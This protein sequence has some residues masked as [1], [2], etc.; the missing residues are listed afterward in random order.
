MLCGCSTTDSVN[1][2]GGVEQQQ[3]V[4]LEKAESQDKVIPLTVTDAG[5]ERV[6]VG[7][8]TDTPDELQP[9]QADEFFPGTGVFL[10]QP[11][12]QPRR[13]KSQKGDFIVNLQDADIQQV[14]ATILG[15]ILDENYL[16]DPK[17][18][19]SVTLQTSRPMD[20]NSLLSALEAVLTING[21]AMVRDGT[22]FKIVPAEG[23]LASGIGSGRAGVTAGRGH[24]TRV[25]PLEYVAAQEM[26]E[27]LEPVAPKGGVLTV[28]ATRNLLIIGGT[29]LELNA[30]M[31]MVE[32]F[33]VD[34]LQ[35]M[36]VGLVKIRFS[37]VQAVAEEIGQIFNAGKQD[38]APGMLR[39]ISI[40]R[41]NSLLVITTQAGYLQ[42]VRTWVERLDRPGD[43]KE[44]RLFVYKLRNGRAEDLAAML[45]TLF[46]G[47][48]AVKA[49][50]DAEEQLAPG[51]L[52][53]EA[54]S[55]SLGSQARVGKNESVSVAGQ[56][57]TPAVQVDERAAQPLLSGV[58]EISIIAE[59]AQNA[60]VI[61][62]SPQDYLKIESAIRRLDLMP[63]QVLVEASIID[64]RL[65]GELSYG[66]QWFFSNDLGSG[67]SGEGRVGEALAFS[68]TFNYTITNS[69]GEV[70]ALLRLLASEGNVNVL[71][72]PSLMVLD[73]HSA[74]I[75][76][77][78]QQPIST[79]LVSSQGEVV[80][81][82][83]QFKDTGVI[84]EVTPRVNAEG[85]VTL[86]ISQEVTDV[87]DI[88]DATGQRSFLQRSIRS[89]VVVQSGET[90]ILGGLIREN[91]AKTQSGV[92][93]L[94]KLPIV[95]HLFGQTVTS[96]DRTEL[97]VLITPQ[98]VRNQDEARQVTEEYRRKLRNVNLSNVIQRT[99]VEQSSNSATGRVSEIEGKLTADRLPEG[100]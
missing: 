50:S 26:K 15:D 44:Q 95:G 18:K 33:D 83:V 22:L 40:E 28:D 30:M 62:A 81:T 6:N 14:V 35:G 64:V 25:V 23:A 71:S 37:D 98:V 60:L 39:L 99:S 86:D 17:V 68:S 54:V 78:D 1:S 96:S 84:L 20:R 90:V 63:L 24:Q 38:S 88:D 45:T 57:T 32:L 52:P 65:T 87:G 80:A 75:R 11:L 58:G 74:T 16:I 73:N 29:A 48:Q 67:K 76:V 19:G 8:E 42:N 82:S 93:G 3:D 53:F 34:W 5:R 9:Q 69:V 31:E 51:F 66:L 10:Q 72:S 2:V 85:L 27:I 47:E 4:P 41:T 56:Q 43:G 59:K 21:A 92:P 91:K 46:R 97:L 100:E 79:A 77:G 36:S 13:K 70:R 49:D 89:S 12:T 61:L 7:Q 55:R 94:R